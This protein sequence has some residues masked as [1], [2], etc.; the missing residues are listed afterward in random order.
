MTRPRIRRPPRSTGA[1]MGFAVLG[2][3]ALIISVIISAIRSP[4]SEPAPA[5]AVSAPDRYPNEWPNPP[6]S[7]VAT[8]LGGLGPNTPLVG[9]W[10]VRGISAVTN[11]RIVIDVDRGDIGMRVWVVRKES[12]PRKPPAET[13]RYALYTAQPRP[14]ADSIDD[15]ASGEVLGALVERIKQ[16]EASAPFPAGM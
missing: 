2:A 11:G 14:N 12:D 13:A 9:R 16:T 7:D 8:L 10:R 5:P 3:S 15:Q 4:S 1:L 6:P